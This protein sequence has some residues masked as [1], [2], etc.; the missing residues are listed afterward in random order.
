MSSMSNDNPSISEKF[1]T[2]FYNAGDK[3]IGC[4][5]GKRRIGALSFGIRN[6]LT[7]NYVQYINFS[8]RSESVI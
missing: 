2:Y 3:C 7:Q 5:E 8:Q 1:R 4:S 6:V